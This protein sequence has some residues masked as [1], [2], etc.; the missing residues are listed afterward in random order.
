M[1]RKILLVG[2]IAT[3]LVATGLV[4]FGTLPADTSKVVGI[5][6]KVGTDD[7]MEWKADGTAYSWK[8]G[9]VYEGTWEQINATTVV[10]NYKGAPSDLTYTI[11]EE[12]VMW[13]DKVYIKR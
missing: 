11:T 4:Y 6:D 10:A 3:L 5:Y 7:W 12:G 1:N 9:R 13:G 8:Y 2:M